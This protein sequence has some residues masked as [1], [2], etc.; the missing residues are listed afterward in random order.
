[1]GILLDVLRGVTCRGSNFSLNMIFEPEKCDLFLPPGTTLKQTVEL[2]RPSMKN[3]RSL[4][5]GSFLAT[6]ERSTNP[7]LFANYLQICGY[8]YV[9]ISDLFSCSSFRRWNDN[10]PDSSYQLR[11]YIGRILL[12]Q[13]FKFSRSDR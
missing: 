7:S 3:E 8:R 9:R 11:R 13:D 12:L 5:R 2:F 6:L 4:L 10:I 1:M